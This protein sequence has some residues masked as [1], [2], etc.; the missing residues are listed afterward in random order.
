VVPVWVSAVFGLCA[1]GT[2]QFVNERETRVAENQ[3]TF[4][5]LNEEIEGVVEDAGDSLTVRLIPFL[6]ECA[7]ARCTKII[8]LTLREYEDIRAGPRRF[9]VALGHEIGSEDEQ[10]VSQS[11]RFTTVEK[12]GEPGRMAAESDPR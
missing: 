10:V 7:D 4:R 11:D 5:R 2:Q 3:T 8:R 1:A 9:A 12:I 6:C